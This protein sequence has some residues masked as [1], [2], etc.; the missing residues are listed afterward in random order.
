MKSGF[1]AIEMIV[2]IA[3]FAVT[4]LALIAFILMFYRGNNFAIEQAFAVES[5]R[6]GVEQMVRDIREVSFSDSGAYPLIS[7][8]TTSLAFYSDID[9]DQS[10]ERIRF[11]LNGTN[12]EKGVTDASGNPPTYDDADEQVSVLSDHVRNIAQDTVIFTYFD[13]TGSEIL[14][15]GRVADV[16]FVQVNL[17]VNINPDRLPEEFTLR[18]SATL[19]NLKVNL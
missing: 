12:F 8:S 19:R 9:R 1:S 17:I 10:I 15:M 5:A 7:M 11:S 16:A 14:D 4:M 13:S 6:K 2:T 3:L 18:S